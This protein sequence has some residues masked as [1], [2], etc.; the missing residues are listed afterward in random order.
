MLV[1][2]PAVAAALGVEPATAQVVRV[3]P[4]AAAAVVA[5]S[6]AV[7]EQTLPAVDSAA[8]EPAPQAFAV[9]EPVAGAEIVP[10]AHSAH[11][12]S[13]AAAP[14]ES[15]IVSPHAGFELA[16]ALPFAAADY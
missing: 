1:V 6:A 5:S 10:V 16:K 7:A 12:E 3:F 9:A 11:D 13:P 4:S 8:V 2:E 15:A 14:L